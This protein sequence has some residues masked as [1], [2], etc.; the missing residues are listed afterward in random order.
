MLSQL[1]LRQYLESLGHV[2]I[3]R[4]VIQNAWN[5]VSPDLQVSDSK[6]GPDSDFERHVVDVCF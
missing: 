5:A 2:Y 1:G 3:V 6:E 4:D